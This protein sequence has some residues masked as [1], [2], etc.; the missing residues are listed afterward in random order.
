MSRTYRRKNAYNKKQYVEDWFNNYEHNNVFF[1]SKNDNTLR[2][3]EVRENWYHSDN[4][5]PLSS[6]ALKTL[7]S[8]S[9]QNY[10]SK[11]KNNIKKVKFLN[12][13]NDFEDYYGYNNK[14]NPIKYCLF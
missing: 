10:R 4:Y 12:N 6:S 13:Y 2:S 14:K 8:L 7:K 11:Y 5:K 1:S 9:N 3:V